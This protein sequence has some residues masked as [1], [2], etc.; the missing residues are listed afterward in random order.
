MLVI[1]AHGGIRKSH[2]P[3]FNNS[4]GTLYFYSPHGVVTQDKGLRNFLYDANSRQRVE[5]LPPNSSCYDYSLCKYQGKHGGTKGNPAE[6]Y[7]SIE[8]ELAYIYGAARYI[9]SER[10]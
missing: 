1:S 10:F 2:S 3:K 6:T 9:G 8:S 7:Q 4:T 5:T